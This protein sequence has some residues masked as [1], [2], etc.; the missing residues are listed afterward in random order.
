MPDW[1]FPELT[2]SWLPLIVPL[3]VTGGLLE[4]TFTA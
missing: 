2:V 1:R 4:A 3:N